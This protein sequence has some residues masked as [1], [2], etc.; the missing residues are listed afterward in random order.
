MNRLIEQ[1]KK[2]D[3]ETIEAENDLVELQAR[4]S[5]AVSRLARIRRIREGVKTRS[6]QLFNRGMDELEK[7]SE[8][9]SALDSHENWVV[10]DLQC[11][12]VPN[13]TD[14]SSFGIGDDFAGV[15]QLTTS[16][17]EPSGGTAARG[18]SSS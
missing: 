3:K 5:A 14:W 17:G 18:E 12:G 2:L 7:E 9:L 1:Q 10:N 6:E 8:T 16:V 13:E 15:G 4:L 11:L